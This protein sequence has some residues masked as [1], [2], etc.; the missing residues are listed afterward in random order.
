[1]IW[2]PEIIKFKEIDL[3]I[4]EQLKDTNT[5]A[6]ISDWRCYITCILRKNAPVIM[7]VNDSW[8]SISWGMFD[9][10]DTVFSLIIL[11]I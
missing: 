8:M 11:N 7:A 6:V 5:V 10:P 3:L 4:S 1:M 2:Q 9:P